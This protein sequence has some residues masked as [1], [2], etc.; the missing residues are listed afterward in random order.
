MAPVNPVLAAA[1]SLALA[2]PGCAYHQ[3]RVAEPNGYGDFHSANSNAYFW[4]AVEETRVADK[5]ATNL[6][7]EVRVVTSV[8]QALATVLTLGIW[9][10]ATVKYKCAKRPILPDE[11]E[12]GEG[13]GRP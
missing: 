10:P 6:I 11:D 8:P 9:M 1:L 12:G 4:G 13:A 2:L 3:L 7:D 5:C